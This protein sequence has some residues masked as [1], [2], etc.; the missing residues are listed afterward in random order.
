[1]YENIEKYQFYNDSSRFSK[2]KYGHGLDMKIGAPRSDEFSKF[3]QFVFPQPDYRAI[4]E[5]LLCLSI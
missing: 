5:C 1:M 2:Y 4:I 3:K